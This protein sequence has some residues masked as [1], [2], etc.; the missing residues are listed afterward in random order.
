MWAI[1]KKAGIEPAPRRSG[2]AWGQF[3]RAQAEGILACDFFHAETVTLA[4]LYCFAVVEHATRRVHILG[5]TA[6]PTA[7]WV[8]QQARNLMMDLGERAGSFKFMIRDQDNKFT[9]LFDGAFR[10]EGSRAYRCSGLRLLRR[11]LVPDDEP[12]VL[13][14]DPDDRA[15]LDLAGEQGAADAGL[16]LAGDEAAQRPGAVDRVEALARR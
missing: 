6:N 10:A 4:R 3:L 11:V 1:L 2:P 5:V 13:Q 9:A 8:A 16:D 14:L 7:D 15:V 12:V